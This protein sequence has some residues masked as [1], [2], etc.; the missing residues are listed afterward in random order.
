[1][2]HKVNFP[3]FLSHLCDV[4]SV[5]VTDDSY[6]DFLSHLCDVEY[7]GFVIRPAM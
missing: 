6:I 3:K 4:E 5:A 7:R 1:M 2:Q